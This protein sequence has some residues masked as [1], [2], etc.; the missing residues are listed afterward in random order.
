MLSDN[1]CASHIIYIMAN[2]RILFISQE[3]T[4][5]L[6]EDEHSTFGKELPHL[7]HANGYEARL[8]MPRYGAINERRNQLHEVIRLSGLNISI[9][10]SDH[11]LIIKVA[12]LPPAKIQAYFID[13]DDYFQRLDSDVDNVGSNR[14]DNDE[15]MI[16]YTR[17]TVETAKKLRWDSDVIVCTGWMAALAPMYLRKIY[18]DEP[19]FKKAKIVTIFDGTKFEGELDPKFIAKLK[20]EGAKDSDLRMIRNKPLTIGALQTLAAKHS[21]GVIL[22]TPDLEPE[23]ATYLETTK[24]KILPHDKVQE[25]GMNAYLDFINSFVS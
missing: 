18:N 7:F 11:P 6:S 21:N 8:F 13:N 2:K 20:A 17:G 12:S 15:R 5:Y 16:F 4:P 22:Q 23:L 25:G 14:A 19:S 10:D 1:I 3:V 24:T 9:G